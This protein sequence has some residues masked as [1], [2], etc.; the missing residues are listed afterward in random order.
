[1]LMISAVRPDLGAL[2]ARLGRPPTTR[3]APSP[4]GYLHLGHIVNAIYTWG[5]ARALG[6]RV[7]LRIE[8]HDRTRSRPEFERA[9]LEELDWLGFMPDV[10]RHPVNRQS[11]RPQRYEA[12]LHRLR[13]SARVYACV[14]SRKEIGGGRYPN[15]CRDRDYAEAPGRGLRV[16]IHSRDERFDDALAGPIRQSPA[17]D[18][19]DLLVRDRDGNWTYQFAVAVDD[20]QEGITLVVRGVDLLAST[21]R[22]VYLARLLGRIDPP[23]FAHHPLLVNASGA[24]LSK[25]VGD[26]GVRDLRAAGMGPDQVIGHAAAACGLIEREQRL[27]AAD[28]GT[29]FV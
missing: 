15:T 27:G 18:A 14:C 22:Q 20:L 13:Q 28:V 21:G 24:K 26:T 7:I 23:G 12:A 29:L 1:M 16:E 25:A 6:G 9:L 5:L 4:T 19:G 10:G 8:D 2:A 11:D 17:D 3:F